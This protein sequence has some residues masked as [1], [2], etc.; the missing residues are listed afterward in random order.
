[1]LR[2]TKLKNGMR[3]LANKDENAVREWKVIVLKVELKF[4]INKFDPDNLDTAA[5][6]GASHMQHR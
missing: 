2:K 1:M 3:K 5:N 4:T 6:Q